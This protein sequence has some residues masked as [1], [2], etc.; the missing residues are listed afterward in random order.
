VK[1]AFAGSMSIVWKT[2]IGISGI[3]LLSVL[4]MKEIPLTNVKDANYA[5]EEKVIKD[6]EKN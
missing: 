2:M 6:D 1:V 4:L 3:G 5:L